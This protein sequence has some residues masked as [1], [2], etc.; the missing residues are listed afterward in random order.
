MPNTRTKTVAFH[1]M[2]CRLLTLATFLA[3]TAYAK[4][5]KPM[6]DRAKSAEKLALGNTEAPETT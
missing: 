5:T 3:A 6:V 1:V 2:V 4:F